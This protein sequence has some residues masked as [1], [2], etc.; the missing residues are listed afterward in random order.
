MQPMLKA[1]NR[2]LPKD[3]RYKVGLHVCKLQRRN[4]LVRTADLLN[5]SEQRLLME[6]GCI[7]GGNMLTLNMCN[8]ERDTL[9]PWINAYNGSHNVYY[10]RTLHKT[11][12][13]RNVQ[14]HHKRFNHCTLHNGVFLHTFFHPIP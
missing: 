10:L 7:C 13:W 2:R 11:A 9:H 8:N 12:V 5:I 3:I 6:R 4:T 14:V 1:I